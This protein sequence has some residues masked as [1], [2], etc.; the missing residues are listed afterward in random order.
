LPEI[1]WGAVISPGLD[2]PFFLYPDEVIDLD[3]MNMLT[4]RLKRELRKYT[5]VN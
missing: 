5:Q 3:S 1:S 4:F 2:N